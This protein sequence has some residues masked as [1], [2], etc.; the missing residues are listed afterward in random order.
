[1][2]AEEEFRNFAKAG[3]P[4]DVMPWLRFFMPGKLKAHQEIQNMTAD[5]NKRIIKEHMAMEG[6]QSDKNL[7]DIFL[8][9]Q[10]PEKVPDNR[11][12]LTKKG[13]M[14]APADL[15]MAGFETTEGVM[16]WLLFYM[17]AYPDVQSQVQH[18]IDEVVGASRKVDIG[19]R[20]KLT[21]TDATIYEVLRISDITPFVLPHS[22]LKDTVLNGYH[23]TKGTV[24][25]MNFNSMH[26]DKTFWGDPEVFR[27]S[28]LIDANNE[29]DKEKLKHISIF[30]L[31]HRRCI[32]E[33]F[34]KMEVFLLFSTLMQK[35][36]FRKPKEDVLD[37]EPLRELLYRPKSFRA[38]VTKRE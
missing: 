31:G 9:V 20:S 2:K 30:G 16:R 13:L 14:C 22:V 6:R 1:M 38:I 28:R 34:A 25:M 23:I 24:A 11:L 21:Y 5:V 18:E 29:L 7:T 19:D 8:D 3:N 27:P 35:C 36:C 32:G 33:H 37:F 15:I 17:I 26:F 12:A 4:L 10:L